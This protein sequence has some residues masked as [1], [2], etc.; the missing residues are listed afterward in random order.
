M[1]ARPR[2]SRLKSL[3]GYK[4]GR[5]LKSALHRYLPAELRRRRS[6]RSFFRQFVSPGDLCFDIG[7]NVG[8]FADVFVELGARVICVE[9]QD[10]CV[11][12]LHKR[13]HHRPQVQIV[14]S[15]VGDREG[16]AELLVCVDEPTISTLSP[17]WTQVGRF[18]SLE[19]WERTQRVPLTTL[20]ALIRLYGT[21]KFCKIDVEGYEAQVI[22][23]LTSPIPVISFEFTREMLSVAEECTS[24]LAGLGVDTFNA[25]LGD[26][27]S[28]VFPRWVS[29]RQVIQHLHEIPNR[30]LNGD[31]Y[32]K[33]GPD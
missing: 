23:G 32:A 11:R 25:V 22:S 24:R 10:S 26:H 17:T 18:S 5:A 12:R 16:E 6:M 15:A 9:P 13:F 7:S 19:R 33:R 14:A 28:P 3:P 8:D 20:D 30:L 31:I 1:S 4:L 27:W 2:S 21:P 29:H